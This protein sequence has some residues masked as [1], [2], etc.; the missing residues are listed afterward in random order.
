MSE[1]FSSCLVPERDHTN[2]LSFA[3]GAG[4]SVW[5]IS[6]SALCGQFHT[7]APIPVIQL[8][9]RDCL[10]LESPSLVRDLASRDLRKIKDFSFC[11]P[12]QRSYSLCILVHAC[13][14]L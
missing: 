5:S 2:C 6:P 8:G 1:V 3:Q 13:L 10:Q 12:A 7:E 14:S 9:K 4:S 11:S